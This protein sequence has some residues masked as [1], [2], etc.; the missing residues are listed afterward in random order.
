MRRGPSRGINMN[1]EHF[2]EQSGQI[3]RIAARLDVTGSLIV[4]AAAV[5]G[6]DIQIVGVARARTEADPA[7]VVIGLRVVELS[8]I[9]SLFGSAMSGFPVTENCETCVTPLPKAPPGTVKL[10]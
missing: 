10:R 6:G 1:A 7:P 9:L 2:A 5:S 8:R 3:L 4:P